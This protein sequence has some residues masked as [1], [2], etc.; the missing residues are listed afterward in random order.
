MSDKRKALIGLLLGA[1]ALVVPQVACAAPAGSAS[2]E[3]Q[4]MQRLERLE[5]EMAQ[6]RS[7]LATAKAAQS[8]AATTT[9]AVAA[10]VQQTQTRVATLEAKPVP[11]VPDGMKAGATTIKLGGYIKLLAANSRYSEGEVATNSLGR[12]FY[13]P[14]AIPTGVGPAS[15]VQ[16]FTAKQSRF[17]LNF[18]TDVAGHSL[19]GYVETD[20]Q[21]SPGTQGSQRTTNGY[22]LALRRAYVQLDKFTFGQ[23]WTTFQ[24][25]GAL[26]ES[27]DYVGGAEGTVFVRQPQI[28]YSTPLSKQVT[29]H[30]SAEN[31][32]SGTLNAG[33]ATLVEN[34]DD[35][36]PD[37]AARLAWADKPGELSLGLLA[38][39]VR[40][41]NAGVAAQS[42]GFGVSAAGKLWLNKDKTGDARFMVTYGRNIGRYV[43]LNFAPDGVY[44]AASN[45][46]EDVKLLSAIGALRIPLRPGLRANVMASYQTVDYSDNLALASIS[47]FNKQA[48]SAAANLFWSPVKAVD[49][50]VEYRHGERKLVSGS[51]GAIDRVEFAAKYNF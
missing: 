38:R 34:G 44:V 5:A 15:R 36:M 16:D 32:E 35:R 19:K 7:D 17:W 24:Y 20:F 42:A 41:E 49:L 4:L 30:V 39:Q 8:D 27:T 48:W 33:S 25:T 29:L 45:K 2:R 22:N 18:A 14:Q 9:Q 3:A 28:R 1:S 10:Q 23:D 43:G 37:F 40:T 31:P 50:G 26:P 51:Q 12:D 11:V 6:L 46:L 47:T 21:T 13:L